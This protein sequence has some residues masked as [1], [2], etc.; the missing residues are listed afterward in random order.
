MAINWTYLRSSIITGLFMAGGVYGA[1]R[2]E[3]KYL[4]R[5]TDH[6]HRRIDDHE[7]HYHRRHG[8]AGA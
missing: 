4:R 5:D 2:V 6:A 8:E 7:K 3:L 1:L